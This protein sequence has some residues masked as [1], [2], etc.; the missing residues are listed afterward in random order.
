MKCWIA[1]VILTVF[2][3]V[4][5]S[6][7]S[8][9]LSRSQAKRLIIAGL[10]P[11]PIGPKKV[12][13]EYVP[14]FHS[15]DWGTALNPG[16]FTLDTNDGYG[17]LAGLEKY[18][19]HDNQSPGNMEYTYEALRDSGY[20]TIK[21]GGPVAE[22]VA[23]SQITYDHSRTIR[24][25]SKVGT[26]IDANDSRKLYSTG[27]SCYPAPDFHQCDMPPLIQIDGTHF[28]VTGIVQPDESHAK[29]NIS[30]PWKLTGFGKELQ[31]FAKNVAQREDKL[32]TNS[33]FYTY[34]SLYAWEHF[35]NRVSDSGSSSATI[36]F[37]KFDDGWRIVDDK[38]K[39]EK[40]FDQ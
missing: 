24:L 6:G 13:G 1:L 16:Y 34:A 26:V 11:H 29:V 21:E 8:G 3:I 22:T 10:K 18:H 20:I 30:I 4:G 15:D 33:S 9:T 39:S 31:P 25:T 19:L 40:D 7:C 17:E 27:F 12:M 28:I 36:L 38:G 14:G 37:Q 23:G 2:S 32:G 35:L 5:V